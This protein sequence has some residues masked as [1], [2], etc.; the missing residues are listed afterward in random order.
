MADTKKSFILYC[1]LIHTVRKMPSDK[2]GDLFKHILSY[3]NDENPTTDDLI[4]DLTFEQIKQQLKRDLSKWEEEKVHKSNGGVI[5]NLKRW[6]P[7]LYEQLTKNEID[8][9]DALQIAKDRRVSDT[10]ADRSLPIASIAVSGTVN[11]TVTATVIKEKKKR[12]KKTF[13]PPSQIEVV[14]YFIENGYVSTAALKAYNYYESGNWSDSKGNQ[15]L[16]W[17]Q[18]MQ[19]VWFKDEFL[20]VIP[21][22]NVVRPDAHK[23]NAPF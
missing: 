13:L 6:N 14:E 21:K 8:I 16:N 22:K 12:E 19:S 2:A 11:G 7:D 5:G 15:V 1:D 3:V 10:D 23:N 18:K 17:K 20:A 9:T 4:V